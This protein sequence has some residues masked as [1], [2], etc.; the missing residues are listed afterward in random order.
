MKQK[1]MTDEI[2]VSLET[3]AQAMPWDLVEIWAKRAPE[4]EYSYTAYVAEQKQFGFPSIF[5]TGDTPMAAALDA[6]R[7]AG[8]KRDPDIARKV[9]LAE[10]KAQI[11][12]LQA[13]VC[14]MPPY[15]PNRELA[16][17]IPATKAG[18][19]TLEV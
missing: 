1:N 6:M 12:K 17:M 10:L 9:K 14:G 15:R 8:G 19:L 5:G 13:V 11:E 18:D 2:M 3:M 16:E 4:G 7:E